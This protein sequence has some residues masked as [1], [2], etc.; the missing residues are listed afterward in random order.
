MPGHLK[1]IKFRMFRNNV[2]VISYDCFILFQIKLTLDEVVLAVFLG[3]SLVSSLV[4]VTL[5][6]FRM[7]RPWGIYLVVLYLVFLTVAILTE[8]KV[9]HYVIDPGA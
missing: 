7:S 1:Y 9:I 8:V 2:T 6:K 3:L 4:I 5:S